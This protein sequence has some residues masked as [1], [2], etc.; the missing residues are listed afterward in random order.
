M[1]FFDDA[2]YN[3]TGDTAPKHTILVTGANHNFYNTV[4]TPGLFSA[5]TTDDWTAFT[6]GG[7]TDPH[8]GTGLAY[9]TRFFRTYIGG[10]SQFLPL[11]TGD[12]PPPSASTTNLF[13]S[14]HAPDDANLGS[15]RLMQR[16]YT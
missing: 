8:C 3:V 6:S 7:S 11:L 5:G 15:T 1:H 13:V 10:E 9:I 14:Y 16:R 12:A 2:R 4:W